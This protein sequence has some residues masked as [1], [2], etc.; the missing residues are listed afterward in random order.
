MWENITLPKCWFEG[1]KREKST[2]KKIR[3]KERR[4]ERKRGEK[5]SVPVSRYKLISFSKWHS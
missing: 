5:R 3:G 2:G 4:I 1:S